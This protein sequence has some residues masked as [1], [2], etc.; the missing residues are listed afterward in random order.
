MVAENNRLRFC[1]GVGVEN[2]F[3]ILA[4]AEIEHFVGFIEH[5]DLQLGKIEAAAL[6]VVAQ[7][8]RRADDDMHAFGEAPPL[9]TR[10]HA[11]DASRDARLGVTIEPG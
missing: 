5:H 8:A 11:A 7:T 10:I 9:L 1:A 2:E 6:D 3:E 4:E